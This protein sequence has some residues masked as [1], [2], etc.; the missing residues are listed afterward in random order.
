[1]EG[2][3]YYQAAASTI[4]IDDIASDDV[5]RKILRRLKENDPNFDELWWVDGGGPTS[6]KGYM[7]YPEGGSDVGWFG[8]FIG[9]NTKL[10]ALTFYSNPF[11]KAIEQFCRGVNS[12]RSIRKIVF[13]GLDL[14]GGEIFQW[15]GPFFE[16]NNNFSEL[17][18]Y[19]CNF[20]VGSARQLSLALRG[21]N[22]SLKSVWISNSQLGGERLV[23]VIHSLS[24]H[25]QLETLALGEMNVGRNECMM[26]LTNLLRNTTT[27]LQEL[28]LYDNSIDDEG[29]ETLVGA[30]ANNSR[31]RVLNVS[32]DQ[33]ITVRGCQ[34]I[35]SLLDNPNSKL[36]KLMLLGNNVGDEGAL[37]FANALASNN[38]LKVLDIRVGNSGITAEGWSSFST[39]LC[40][41]SN[42]NSTL[43]SNH[44][45]ERFGEAP[46][47]SLSSLPA[48][49]KSL[50]TL[51][52]SSED[53]KQVAIKKILKYH[54]HFDMQP[55]FEWELKVLPI[56]V[57]WFERARSVDSNNVVVI[58]RHK[59][60]AIYQ[61]IRAT[62]EIF[63]PAPVA[64]GKKRKQVVQL[65]RNV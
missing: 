60:E 40:D 28:N 4:K 55:F 57:S 36:E 13:S 37:I 2:Y 56:A 14:S 3:E 59:L 38:K 7:Y 21:C 39:V 27:N 19:H 32:H 1:M 63:E 51:N 24:V 54:R 65:S 62:P 48:E 30:L 50:L 15:L 6:R 11:E 44:T 12:N 43:L 33:N 17:V 52:K 46:S 35:A 42:V 49:I 29:V 41:A 18:V 22:K 9:N 16:N 26:A 25:P 45:L 47:S 53:K 8:H 5:N 23:D 34:S 31:L 10:R 64:S 20:G 61:F 58:D